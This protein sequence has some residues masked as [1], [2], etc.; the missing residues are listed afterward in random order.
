MARSDSDGALRTTS[1]I[2]AEVRDSV[3]RVITT[4]N[5]GELSFV[6]SVNDTYE[7]GELN[8]VNITSPSKPSWHLS[9]LSPATR[10]KFYVRACTSRGCGKPL[11]EESLTAGDGSK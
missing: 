4:V 1:I 3:A 5:H 11:T 7:V 8:A 9:N 2:D 6:P 10:Y